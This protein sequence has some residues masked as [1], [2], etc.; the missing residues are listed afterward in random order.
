MAGSAALGECEV[1][2]Y[3]ALVDASLLELVPTDAV[4][5]AV[6]KRCGRHPV[7]QDEICRL[8]ALYARR[9]RRVVRLK[10]GDPGLF[11]RLGE[12][13]DFLKFVGLSYRVIPGVSSLSAATTG[14][15]LL[16]T[17]RGMSR[18]FMVLTPRD[19]EGKF[20]P[21]SLTDQR[22]MPLVFFMAGC[23][24]REVA[25]DLHGQ[26][27]DPNLPVAVVSDAGLESQSVLTGSLGNMSEWVAPAAGLQPVL[28]IV[29][30]TAS[31]R[32][33]Y[34]T[35]GGALR[36]MRVLITCSAEVQDRVAA[37]VAE[38]GG[39]PLR[40]PM[41]RLEPDAS[42]KTAL[43]AIHEF[44]WLILTSPSAVSCLVRLLDDIGTDWRV[45]PKI[46]VSGPHTAAQLRK[47]RLTADVVADVAFGTEEL[48]SAARSHVRAGVSALRCRSDLADDRISLALRQN[49]I[50]V[51]DCVLYRNIPVHYDRIPDFEAVIFMSG[52]AVRAFT[53]NWGSASLANRLRIAIGPPTAAVLEEY[54]QKVTVVA[55]EATSES[56]VAALAAY[57]VGQDLGRCDDHQQGIPRKEIYA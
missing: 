29:G 39:V 51:T 24:I 20:V 10:G 23:F 42:A 33:L 40:Y 43:S 38:Y 12:E 22:N 14:T 44:D 17:R 31:R 52:S 19:G 28:L 30:E 57:V 47:H 2:L 45:L 1:C 56:A 7:E 9:G 46:I 41:I 35:T 16:L 4:R 34:H 36:G 3:D 53:A 48:L 37:L 15:G 55:P 32:F 11:S 54:G 6:G 50:R 13:I 25:A 21:L 8:F 5:I 49:G 26:G 27:Y 18:A